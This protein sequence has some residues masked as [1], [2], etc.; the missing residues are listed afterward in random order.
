MGG[1]GEICAPC[2]GAAIV[3]LMLGDALACVVLPRLV[4]AHAVHNVGGVCTCVAQLVQELVH[5]LGILEQ[6]D[7]SSGK[8]HC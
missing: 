7:I 1:P 2:A 5:S 6:T 8:G 3:G 4:M